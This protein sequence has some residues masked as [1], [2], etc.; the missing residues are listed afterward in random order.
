MEIESIISSL[1]LYRQLPHQSYHWCTTQSTCTSSTMSNGRHYSNL[2]HQ[3]NVAC[4]QHNLH[5]SYIDTFKKLTLL[6]VMDGKTA[7]FQ[8]VSNH[9]YNPRPSDSC[10][11]TT[12]L[13]C[14]CSSDLANGLALHKLS[15][16]HSLHACM[17]TYNYMDINIVNKE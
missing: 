6:W 17:H 5:E 4:S 14:T 15:L 10:I 7:L 3:W 1:L 11:C 9:L 13:H 8:W 16:H 2:F 12:D